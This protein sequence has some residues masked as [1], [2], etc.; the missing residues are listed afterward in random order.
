MAVYGGATAQLAEIPTVIPVTTLAR[1]IGRSVV[2][3][4]EVDP[5][6]RSLR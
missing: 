6:E 5:S 3:T 4:D 2:Q 1:V